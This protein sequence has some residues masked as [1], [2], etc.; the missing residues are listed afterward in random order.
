V[1]EKAP[2]SATVVFGRS[3][4]YRPDDRLTRQGEVHYVFQSCFHCFSLTERLALGAT[5]VAM[6]VLVILDQQSRISDRI[7]SM[8]FAS[9][10][11]EHDVTAERQAI[12]RLPLHPS[13]V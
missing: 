8:R 2:C 5:G 6:D 10:F 4:G 7:R 3:P 11:D 1:T 13:R 9:A 12:A